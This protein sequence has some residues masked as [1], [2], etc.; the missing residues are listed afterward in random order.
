MSEKFDWDDGCLVVPFHP[1]QN[2]TAVYTN[3]FGEIVLRQK[4]PGAWKDDYD[5]LV[6]FRPEHAEAIVRAIIAEVG[7]PYV[8]VGECSENSEPTARKVTDVTAAER[9]RRHRAKL[10]ERRDPNRDKRDAAA[11]QP[12]LPPDRVQLALVCTSAEDEEKDS[13]ETALAR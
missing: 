8:L 13:Q 2:E 12:P 10:R 1:A 5:K 9:Q 4:T 6:I 11:A 3:A 7:L